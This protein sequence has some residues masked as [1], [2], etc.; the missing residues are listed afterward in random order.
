MPQRP[1][2]LPTT[3][4]SQPQAHS[5]TLFILH[6]LIKKQSH[7]GLCIAIQTHRH[8]PLSLT[9]IRH[10]PPQTK[11]VLIYSDESMTHFPSSCIAIYKTR[12][13][14]QTLVS[15]TYCTKQHVW[16]RWRRVSAGVATDCRTITDK[17]RRWSADITSAANRRSHHRWRRDARR[18]RNS[19]SRMYWRFS[20]KYISNYVLAVTFLRLTAT[21][22]IADRRHYHRATHAIP[23]RASDGDRL[24]KRTIAD[25][26][27]TS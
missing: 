23:R 7:K 18:L 2:C 19:S 26:R 4:C 21:P 6:K 12:P 10:S 27:I 22:T 25:R 14:G 15:S 8:R 11:T 5:K 13:R 9:Q 24:Q 3:T 20:D 1:L 16:E 17:Y